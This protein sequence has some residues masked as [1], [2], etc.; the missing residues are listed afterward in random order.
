MTQKAKCPECHAQTYAFLA[1]LVEA[2]FDGKRVRTHQVGGRYACA[3]GCV[4]RVLKDGCEVERSAHPAPAAPADPN[5]KPPA[6]PG[7]REVIP[8]RLPRAGR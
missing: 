5:A 1:A 2:T 7:H 3:C 6:Q 8:V 4:F